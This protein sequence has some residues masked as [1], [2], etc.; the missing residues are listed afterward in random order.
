MLSAQDA[1]FIYL[2]SDHSPM[3]IGGVYLVDAATAPAG[4][5]FQRFKTHIEQRLALSPIFRRRLVEAPLN[6]SHPCWINDPD[7]DLNLHLPHLQLPQ[8]GGM[9]ELMQLAAQVFGKTLDRG[10]PLWE[11]NFVENLN[12]VAGLS[13]GS[14]ALISK[15]HHAAVD[16]GSGVELMGALL[17]ISDR[18]RTID[19]VDRWQPEPVPGT[20]RLVAAA[21]SRMG[22]K[23]V[24]LARLLGDIAAGAARA[25][26]SRKTHRINP[27][28]M[29]FSAPPTVLNQ[30]VSSSRTYWGVDF[31]F[32][33]IRRIRKFMPGAT[34]NDVVL[35]I[36]AAGLRGYLMERGALPAQPL[37]AMAPIS[38]RPESQKAA[39]GN[40]VSAML[41]SLATDVADPLQRVLL[42]GR[43]TRGSKAYADALPA[44][45]IAE[46]IPSETLAA[47]AR[48]YTRTRLGGRHRPFFNLTVTNVPGPATPLYMAGARLSRQFGMAPIMDG[49][50]LTI[51]VLSYAGRI[52][53]G[54][55]SCFK[56][57]PDPHHLAELL[58]GAL[59][60]LERSVRAATPQNWRRARRAMENSS[61]VAAQPAAGGAGAVARLREATR[62]LDRAI[63]RLEKKR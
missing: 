51:V 29:V 42:I 36:C 33:R 58:S 13:K 59:D 35:A 5:N 57:I 8:P 50:G 20:S 46:F 53:L 22:R 2:E 6:L 34:V 61:S 18:P 63:A 25:Y 27:P 31:D 52:S 14:F 7:F 49:L 56:V 62:A 12:E 15:V 19:I 4:F 43:N 38:V 30:A 60:E 44:N 48:L 28:P 39:M 3:H 10:R 37:V 54:L 40:Q 24:A 55:T 23:S 41:V 11:F 17:D 45:R 9:R 26:N 21:Y 1:A 32:E 47:A 16:G